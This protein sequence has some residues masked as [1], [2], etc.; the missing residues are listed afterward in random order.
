MT[1]VVSSGVHYPLLCDIFVTVFQQVSR[2]LQF[3]PI[4]KT[5]S[6]DII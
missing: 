2:F 3:L 6:H 1:Q 5:D 4:K